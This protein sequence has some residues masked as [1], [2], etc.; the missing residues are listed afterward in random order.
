MNQNLIKF[1]RPI[2]DRL[3]VFAF[4]IAI[5][6]MGLWNPSKALNIALEVLDTQ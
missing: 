4:G 1:L 5:A 3:R 2:S 6:F